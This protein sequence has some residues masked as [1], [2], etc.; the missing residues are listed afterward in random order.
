MS[1]EEDRREMIKRGEGS[2]PHMYLDT[3]GYVTVGVGHMMPDTQA[4]Q[5]L[6]FVRRDNEE[7]ATTAEIAQDFATISARPYGQSYGHWTFE[8]YATLELTASEID[9]L[10]DRRLTEFESRLRRDFPDYDA[11]PA[12]ARLGLMDMAFNLGNAGLVS[13]FP[14]FTRAARE[15]DWQ[16]CAEECRRRGI[17]S[18][19]NE[20]TKHLFEAAL[21]EEI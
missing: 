19:R 7:P 14:T 8:S 18:T 21:V 17:S 1:F 10:L 13:K 2:V 16:T 12:P 5:Q 9:R 11:C 20:E 4:A 3:R 6:P 15:G